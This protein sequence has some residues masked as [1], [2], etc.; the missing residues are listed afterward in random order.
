MNTQLNNA[1]ILSGQNP[2]IDFTKP[3]FRFVSGV[4]DVPVCAITNIASDKIYVSNHPPD[5]SEDGNWSLTGAKVVITRFWSSSTAYF[6]MTFPLVDGRAYPPTLPVD[7]RFEQEICIY[8]G[9]LDRP[10]PITLEDLCHTKYKDKP[11][12]LKRVYVGV[13]EV[14]TTTFTANGGYTASF[15]CRDRMKWLMDTTTTFNPTR[16]TGEVSVATANSVGGPTRSSL[17]YDVARRGI[18]LGAA[19]TDN[20]GCGREI[21][22]SEKFSYDADNTIVENKKVLDPNV[23]YTNDGPLMNSLKADEAR[24][25]TE[26]PEFRIYTSRDSL[27]VEQKR[28]FLI[29]NQ[30]P[31]ELIKYLALQEV[32]PTEVFQHHSDG[33]FYYVPRMNA[34]HTL[35]QKDLGYRTYFCKFKPIPS[36]EEESSETNED[37]AVENEAE[38]QT[39]AQSNTQTSAQSN[40]Q[41]SAQPDTQTTGTDSN[42]DPNRA[43][44][45][46]GYRTLR[47]GSTEDF[48]KAVSLNDQ[49][50][51]LLSFKEEQTSVGLKTNILVRNSSSNVSGS[52][53]EANIH[54]KTRPYILK[55]KD[56]DGKVP[57]FACKFAIYQDSTIGNSTEAAVIALNMAR[58]L[59]KETRAAT[60]V[61]LGDPTLSPGEICQV[62]NSPLQYQELS[63]TR[64]AAL[65]QADRAKYLSFEN[66]S[67][68]SAI[69][70]MAAL[71]RAE[72][73]NSDALSSQN[74]KLFDG[75]EAQINLYQG[76]E[77]SSNLLCNNPSKIFSPKS[78]Q[79]ETEENTDT[80]ATEDR[81]SNDEADQDL[82]D[83]IGYNE[84]PRSMWRIEALIHNYN[85]GS[86][87][88][89][90]EVA[91]TSPF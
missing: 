60:G 31:I 71:K 12:R 74:L 43:T 83:L 42:E 63:E 2:D 85:M 64:M 77:D 78:S 56:S 61:L 22:K 45:D 5:F 29:A 35:T 18:G 84:E 36:F 55:R 19:P 7:L 70:Y 87:G 39:S 48:N 73:E 23:W 8:M 40:T 10:R 38:T 46:E 62:V 72:A 11:H 86:Q 37:S 9:Y 80:S 52:L 67:I 66:N 47:A 28:D 16:D 26:N 91:W 32:Y 1:G 50:Q 6:T 82:E 20:C 88:Y 90:T 75:T 17:I 49:N 69:E 27:E 33:H 76:N 15:Q 34:S 89:K 51:M 65:M 24:E 3:N 25:P 4:F 30:I 44:R 57:K 14:I 53:G 41:T 81:A 68:N 21:I 54:L 58:I 13:I 59:G 79:S